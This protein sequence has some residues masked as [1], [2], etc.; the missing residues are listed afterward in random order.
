MKQGN[1]PLLYR[2][3]VGLS[4]P[5]RSDLIP[6]QEVIDWLTDRLESFT[7]VDAEGYFRGHP[8]PTLIISVTDHNPANV[9]KLAQALRVH[10]S[11]DGIGIEPGGN[12]FRATACRNPS[13]HSFISTNYMDFP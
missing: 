12:Y 11:Q 3:Y 4:R 10:F 6:R 1:T 9:T 7:V 13:E 2:L 5:D 8:E